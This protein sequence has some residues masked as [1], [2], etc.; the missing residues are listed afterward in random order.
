ML[1]GVHVNSKPGNCICREGYSGPLCD[2]CAQGFHGYPNCKP[3]PCSLAGTLN[4]VCDGNCVCKQNVK[5]SKCDK[6]K[7]GYFA[8][9][10]NVSS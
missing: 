3:C 9:L 5:G 10:P 8:V 1:D 6:C 7:L 4:G 2:Q